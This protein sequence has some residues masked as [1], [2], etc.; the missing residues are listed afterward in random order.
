VAAGDALWVRLER[1]APG[2]AAFFVHVPLEA[3]MISLVGVTF[4]GGEPEIEIL[5]VPPQFRRPQ[6]TE[7]RL[8]LRSQQFARLGAWD[9]IA[10]MLQKPPDRLLPLM[11]AGYARL[12]GNQAEAAAESG[13]RLIETAPERA[14]GFI[15][16]AAAAAIR[17]GQVGA[18]VLPNA[19]PLTRGY[20]LALA[21]LYTADSTDSAGVR[22]LLP[23][24]VSNQFWLVVDRAQPARPFRP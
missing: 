11:I 6:V 18:P 14:E 12:A 23:H 24:I 5:I 7:Q 22:D 8:V 3:R 4:D 13:Q 17:T 15:I 1:S 16:R 21:Q 19:L 10:E 20:A 9:D 2:T